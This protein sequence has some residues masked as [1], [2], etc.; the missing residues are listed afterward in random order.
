ARLEPG[1]A[2]HQSVEVLLG[3]L[4]A[5]AVLNGPPLDELLG[6]LPRL[7]VL[8]AGKRRHARGLDRRVSYLR[9]L[10]L[11]GRSLSLW[12]RALLGRRSGG[13]LLPLRRSDAEDLLPAL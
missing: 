7:L 3:S 1:C 11:R 6:A 12:R 5:D 4:D 10:F 9:P 8:L 2:M 13:G